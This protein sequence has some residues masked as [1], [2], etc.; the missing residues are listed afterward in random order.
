[1]PE[2]TRRLRDGNRASK[3]AEYMALF[4]A[5]ESGRSPKARLFEDELARAFLS[6]GLKLANAASRLP[7]IGRLVPAYIDR[8]WPG[9]RLS[10][11]V[12]TRLIDDMTREALGAGARQVVILGAGY[13]TRG[14]R[15][16]DHARV[17]VYEV[18]H[19]ATQAVKRERL[20]RAL[21]SLPE[22]VTFVPI[23][24]DREE[25]A[26]VLE[27][28]GWRRDL[29]SFVIWE[30]VLSYLTPEAVDATLR[31]VAS[32]AAGSRLAFT[33]VDRTSLESSAAGEP[34]PEAWIGAV[35]RV[36]EPFRFGLDPAGLDAYLA[37]RE[38]RLLSDQST[39][40]ALAELKPGLAGKTALPRFYRVALAEV[41]GGG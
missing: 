22:E 31:W 24:F 29:P 2:T 39:A 38:L 6:P 33:Y 14:F 28:A 8:R 10:G 40:D 37:E 7:G 34:S 35:N 21:G 4:R 16:V 30:G 3:T 1:M 32:A 27:T 13:D 41:G 5:I 19:P 18:D 11:A 25:L 17:R 23:D 9:P 15:L 20:A 26:A 12:R 36:G